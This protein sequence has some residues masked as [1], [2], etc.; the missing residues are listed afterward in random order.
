[1]DG[2]T[3]I[4]PGSKVQ[5]EIEKGLNGASLV[6]LVDTPK[7]PESPWIKH[8]VDTANAFLLP[9]FPL[10]FRSEG[11]PKHGPRFQSLLSLQRWVQLKLP[12]P[13][14]NPPLT[15]Q[16]LEEIVSKMET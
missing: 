11:D 14:A 7:T 3:H 6:L 8:E 5:V 1:M 2:D 13:A 9:V 10:C 16:E 4:L 12:N 15:A